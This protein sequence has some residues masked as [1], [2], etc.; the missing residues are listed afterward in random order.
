MEAT[1][2]K[3]LLK[4]NH[5]FALIQVQK[6]NMITQRRRMRTQRTSGGVKKRKLL[7]GRDQEL[8][9]RTHMIFHLLDLWAAHV[10]VRLHRSLKDWMMKEK[11]SQFTNKHT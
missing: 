10:P 9:G 2:Y 6:P 7:Q 4:S 8:S 1:V 3:M 11:E 5:G